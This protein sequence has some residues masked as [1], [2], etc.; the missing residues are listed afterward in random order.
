MRRRR[1]RF[2]AAFS[3]RRR[4]SCAPP[5]ERLTLCENPAGVAPCGKIRTGK[6]PLLREDDNLFAG[7]I[8]EEYQ[9]LQKMCP[10]AALLPRMLGRRLREATAPGAR[11]EGLEIGCGTGVSTL[12][13]LQEN[14][15]L[16]L[17][18]LDSSPQMLAQA[19]SHLRSFESAGRVAFVEADALECLKR[20]ESG[21]YDVVVSNYAIHNFLEEYRRLV[22]AEIFRVLKPGGLFLNGDRYAIDDRAA[23]LELTQATV[24][25]W[26]KTFGE[27]KRYDLLED[28]VVHYFSDES[29]EHIMY[30]APGL[31]QLKEIGFIRVEALHRDGVDALVTAT[32]PA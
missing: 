30:F 29:P 5:R 6:K 14:E 20:Q 2:N 9:F 23:H 1:A 4:H 8:G 28:W 22:L 18:A 27:M 11:L 17:L 13:I 10:N 31:A 12:P 7:P 19:R 32:K 24:R 16:T 26:F 15:G 25:D 21:R 3:R